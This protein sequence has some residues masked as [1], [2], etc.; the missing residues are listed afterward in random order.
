MKKKKK[1]NQEKEEGE[2]MITE[3]DEEEQT[4]EEGSK[5]QEE[6]ETAPEAMHFERGVSWRGS[7]SPCCLK[8]C[9]SRRSKPGD[10]GRD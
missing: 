3:E 6:K 5:R 9:P 1:E 8:R 7:L 2:A 10:N 4:Q